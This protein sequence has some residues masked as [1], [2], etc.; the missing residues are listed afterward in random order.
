MSSRQSELDAALIAWADYQR[1]WSLYNL[2]VIYARVDPDNIDESWRRVI[3]SA[4]VLY[5]ITG[6]NT[7][8]VLD[9]YWRLKMA[10][11]GW[12]ADFDWRQGRPDLPTQLPSGM[13][14]EQLFRHA[15][16]HM[17]WQIAQG[18]P[19]E[20]A[21]KN[22]LSRTA[23]AVGTVTHKTVRD[24]NGNRSDAMRL[25]RSTKPMPAELQPYARE[26]VKVD[27]LAPVEAPPRTPTRT[28]PRT[29]PPPLRITPVP[30][31]PTVPT[32]PDAPAD[33]VPTKRVAPRPTM[34]IELPRVRWR[35][36]PSFNPCAFC[37][38]LA[39]RGAVYADAETALYTRTGAKYHLNCRCTAAPAIDGVDGFV[40][41]QE[42]F[43]RLSTPGKDGNLPTWR[44]S[45]VPKV[46][47][48][49]ERRYTYTYDLSSQS[50]GKGGITVYKGE[51]PT[52]DW[53]N[54]NEAPS[55]RIPALERF[56]ADPANRKAFAEAFL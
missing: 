46:R 9:D 23:R 22:S 44:M 17:K 31:A 41:S 35:R 54:I 55:V 27:R 11:A 5:W 16:A 10:D 33:P 4:I 52:P 14:A 20:Q 1:A 43:E 53:A 21:I 13:P 36:I 7:L 49:S 19:P 30:T 28:P 47:N 24:T 32:L 25:Q 45:T 39:T 42:D 34:R 26:V 3:E 6:A 15:P 48:P 8:N 56:F 12:A 2:N 50:I 37:L 18:V 40:L 38:T 29:T 51:L